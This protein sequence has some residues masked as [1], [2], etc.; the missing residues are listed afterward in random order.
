VSAAPRSKA[1]LGGAGAE[2]GS[3]LV[4]ALAILIVVVLLGLAGVAATV[5]SVTQ[6][7]RGKS[8]TQALE[9]AEAAANIG[10]DRTSL[11]HIDS[12]GLSL[13]TPCLSFDLS[14]DV[15]AVAALTL[16]GETWCP[17]VSVAVP[18]ASSASYQMTELTLGGRYIVGSATV[19]GVTR[20]VELSLNQK[21][22]SS[23]LFGSYALLS[24]A[25]LDMVNSTLVSGA[26]I[27]SDSWIKLEDT[28]VK[29]HI[30]NGSITPG[31]G[32]TV[33]E[34]NNAGTCGNSTTP[35]TSDISF[36]TVS[37]PT[38]NDDSRICT[39]GKDPCSGS[40]TWNALSDSLTLQN[41]GDSVT[42][43]GN[44]YVF[45]SLTLNNGTLNVAP[46]NG[47]A[48]QIYFLPPTLCTLAGLAVGAQ[49]LDV[50]NT[51]AYINNQTGL[52]AQGLQIYMV[53]NNTVNI[54]NSSSTA[55]NAVLYAPSGTI[56][57]ENSATIKGAV[58]ANA[59]TMTAQSNI[60]YDSSAANVTGSG[61]SIL[62]N[63]TQYDECTPQSSTGAPD[64][65]CP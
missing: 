9:A 31:P 37:V 65:G 64:S 7:T 59:V 28:A 14:G 16:G 18:G 45:C 63:Q 49:D 39:S 60:T 11:I 56:N 8:D 38:S 50:Q 62:Y 21:T 44:T 42:L 22:S 32:Q 24:H 13:S 23:S 33:S 5:A 30:P 48:V 10:W 25:S 53:G 12:L 6:A 57:L 41:T 27:R 61:G 43:K 34:T 51:T 17:S 40:V 26:G 52:G 46:S 55:I 58:A 2:D 3:T 20:R 1:A 15:S 29:C 47:K 4:A 19:G 35:A 36:S 54:N